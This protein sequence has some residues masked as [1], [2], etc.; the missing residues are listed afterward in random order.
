M[1]WYGL[2]KSWLPRAA[3]RCIGARWVD[4]DRLLEKDQKTFVDH[5]DL[6]ALADAMTESKLRSDSMCT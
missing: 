3:A 6:L 2:G 1:V 4:L 5:V